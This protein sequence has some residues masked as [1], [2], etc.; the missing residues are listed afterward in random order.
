MSRSE[1]REIVP[2]N[3][4]PFIN[5]SYPIY[6]AVLRHFG[7]PLLPLVLNDLL[8]YR[9]D[10]DPA[11]DR[12]LPH[13]E[14]LPIH[15][16]QQ[17]WSDTFGIAQ[18]TW[19]AVENI[20]DLVKGELA[21]GRP[22]MLSLDRYYQPF[23]RTYYERQHYL[24]NVLVYGYDDARRTFLLFDDVGPSQTAPNA[25]C[26]LDYDQL[27]N[28]YASVYRCWPAELSELPTVYS[29]SA[30]PRE[31]D[32]TAMA[33]QARS[34]FARAQLA[35]DRSLRAGIDAL[36]RFATGFAGA[37]LHCAS[38][39]SLALYQLV[40]RRLYELSQSNM[41]QCRQLLPH[42]TPALAMRCE[43]LVQGWQSLHLRAM[44]AALTQRSAPSTSAFADFVCER[45]SCVV[46][47]EREWRDAYV[48]EMK[49][50]II[51]TSS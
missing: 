27:T 40:F 43:H 51:H 12:D 42:A 14:L 1:L 25:P 4:H 39:S 3:D 41:Q 13:V 9:C 8:Q 34:A 44:K 21:V 16:V 6:F 38:D 18:F 2:F 26:E 47:M 33:Q 11:L 20:T 37:L 31:F 22:V 7:R 24:H 50:S 29:F 48:S 5:C 32:R 17:L 35:H 15:N 19:R 49:L 45:L 10:R 36:Q 28:S 30:E 23:A 46:Q